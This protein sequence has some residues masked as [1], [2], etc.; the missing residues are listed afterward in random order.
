MFRPKLTAGVP[1]ARRQRPLSLSTSPSQTKPC[2]SP[3]VFALWR[4]QA[5]HLRP[6]ISY[7]EVALPLFLRDPILSLGLF[8]PNYMISILN[9]T[10]PHL[11]QHVP[12]DSGAGRM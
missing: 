1:I 4:I 7:S 10:S 12:P 8:L 11:Q 2:L 9:P 6:S 5:S 3:A